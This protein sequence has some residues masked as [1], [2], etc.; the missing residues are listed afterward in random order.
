MDA[1][2][3][4]LLLYMLVFLYFRAKRRMTILMGI[5]YSLTLNIKITNIVQH[6]KF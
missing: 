3:L 4:I 5:L 6:F 2:D 1:T